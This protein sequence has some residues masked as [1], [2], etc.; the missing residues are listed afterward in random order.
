[1]NIKAKLLENSLEK[2]P[3]LGD[4]QMNLKLFQYFDKLKSNPL[5]IQN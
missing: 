5:T 3:K 2:G 4:S 1:M